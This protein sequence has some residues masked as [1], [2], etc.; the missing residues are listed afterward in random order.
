MMKNTLY[1]ILFILVVG[2]LL[3][4]QTPANK[5]SH[6]YSIEGATA[7]IGN[8]QVIEN[9]LLMFS[10]G[11]IIFIGSAK[12]KIARQGKVINAK[13]KHVYPGFIAANSTLGLVE[14]DAVKASDDQREIGIM[15]PHIRSLIAYNTESKVIES[16]RP[17]GV[18]MAQISPR[19]GTL[20]GMS[21]IVQ[22]DAWNWEDALIKADEGI[23]LNWPRYY[24]RSK[25]DKNQLLSHYQTKKKEI[26][27]FFNRAI[28]YQKD[29]K[30]VTTNIRLKAMKGLFNGAQQLYVH[31]N[32]IKEITDI[33]DFKKEFNIS[34]LCIVGGYDSWMVAKRL[35]ENNISIMY[36]FMLGK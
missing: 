30:P 9:S 22:F 27:E 35:K 11:K 2:N 18:L 23:H 5:Q 15:N 10:N 8:G 4:Q 29:S 19:G 7:H 17:N 24:N 20:S 16:M 31:A 14:I 32:Y 34:K 13:D 12:N 6:A 33:I 36:M 3:A 25:K 26:I 1:S 21:S 28:A